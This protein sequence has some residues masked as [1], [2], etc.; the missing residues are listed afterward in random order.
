MI[1]SHMNIQQ[2]NV[3]TCHIIGG[4]SHDIPNQTRHGKNTQNLT[5]EQLPILH[6]LTIVINTY[7]ESHE[8]P[9]TW[10]LVDVRIHIR[11][12]KGY[13]FIYLVNNS[14][15]GRELETAHLRAF[16]HIQYHTITMVIWIYIK[17]QATYLQTIYFMDNFNASQYQHPCIL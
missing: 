1:A 9:H 17:L 13:P 8:I 4:N 7:E 5:A 14:Y 10:S 3:S 11:M 16:Y 15:P 6:L 12:L 2:Q